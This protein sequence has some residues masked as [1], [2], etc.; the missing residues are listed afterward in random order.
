MITLLPARRDY[1]RERSGWLQATCAEQQYPPF[2]WAAVIAFS[3]TW[4]RNFGEY[5]SGTWRRWACLFNENRIPVR[6]C[7]F[8]SLSLVYGAHC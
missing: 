6:A 3:H 2:Q 5:G 1:T 4:A 7:V 8:H